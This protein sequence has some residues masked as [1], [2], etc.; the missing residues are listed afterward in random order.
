MFI[1]LVSVTIFPDS[2]VCYIY[3]KCSQNIQ[4]KT[5]I[6]LTATVSITNLAGNSKKQ[7]FISK[8]ISYILI[9]KYWSAMHCY[10]S[11][12]VC[13]FTVILST[14]FEESIRKLLK[15]CMVSDT[16]VPEIN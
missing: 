15:A 11:I 9:K 4:S 14:N 6:K 10:I 8:S 5:F 1:L 12:C 16:K 2:E 7:F 13:L 3:F